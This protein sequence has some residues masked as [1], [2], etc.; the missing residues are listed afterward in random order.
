MCSD[1]TVIKIKL[2]CVVTLA[3]YMINCY[4]SIFAV[5]QLL[6][7]TNT[8]TKRSARNGQRKENVR[9]T[10]DGCPRTAR[11]LVICVEKM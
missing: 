9:S 6:V 1:K 7:P 3:K 10:H 11:S 2:S 8:L 5:L 4:L